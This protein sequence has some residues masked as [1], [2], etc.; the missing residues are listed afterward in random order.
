MSPPTDHELLA[1]YREHL[2]TWRRSP[3]TI[4]LRMHQVRRLAGDQPGLAR[5]TTASLSAWLVGRDWAAETA[6]SHLAAL[7]GLYG[8]NAG[9]RPQL[10]LCCHALH[11]AASRCQESSRSGVSGCV[12]FTQCVM[13]CG[14]TYLEAASLVALI[15]S[16]F[17]AVAIHRARAA[18]RPCW[19]PRCPRAA[20]W[21]SNDGRQWCANC[22]GVLLT[23]AGLIQGRAE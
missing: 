13:L 20:T 2:V 16:P 7:R 6:R 1:G 4:A 17:I 15:A 21:R 5:A 11:V 10:V 9:H 18:L 22:L 19:T 14:M 23:R 12:T 3:E 8:W